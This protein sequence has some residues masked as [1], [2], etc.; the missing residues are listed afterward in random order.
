MNLASELA[1]W[2]DAPL[3]MKPP[4]L[5]LGHQLTGRERKRVQ[6]LDFLLIL[7]TDGS[8]LILSYIEQRR[9][10]NFEILK[11]VE[12]RL[13]GGCALTHAGSRHSLGRRTIANKR[14][15]TLRYMFRRACC[16]P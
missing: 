9:V 2:A 12:V 16:A 7:L 4:S 5:H 8:G 13:C 15:S 14:A 6:R 11:V 3:G 1:A 10:F